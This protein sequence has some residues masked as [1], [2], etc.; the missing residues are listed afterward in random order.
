METERRE[1]RY[2]PE[3]SIVRLDDGR[4]GIL[5]HR[6]ERGDPM[7]LVEQSGVRLKQSD[8]LEIIEMTG[9]AALRRAA[10][11][12]R[13]ERTPELGGI[14]YTYLV[15]GA[16]ALM[17]L[18]ALDDQFAFGEEWQEEDRQELLD[19][20][21]VEAAGDLSRRIREILDRPGG[22][23]PVGT[24]TTLDFLGWEHLRDYPI[25]AEMAQEWI[26]DGENGD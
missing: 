8:E 13:H 20:F 7:V 25:T 21:S 26:C 18:Q 12:R 5:S 11:L 14:L 23:S 24:L 9:V 22:L 2:I 1:V 17:A 10:F 19:W 15:Q 3:W 6:A 16:E 4:I